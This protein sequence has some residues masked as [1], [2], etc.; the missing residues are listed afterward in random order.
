MKKKKKY[1]LTL[2]DFV[3][4]I[5]ELISESEPAI[6]ERGFLDFEHLSKTSTILGVKMARDIALLMIKKNKESA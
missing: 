2:E 3:N 1:I 5:N 6:G 4:Q